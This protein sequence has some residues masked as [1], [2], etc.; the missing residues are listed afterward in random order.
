MG[1]VSALRR[2]PAVLLMV[3]AAFSWGAGTVVTKVTL[4][5]LSPLDVLGVELLVGT[6]AIWAA[7]L[8]RGGPRGL[9]GWRGFAVLGTL[10]P[11][12]SFALFDFGLDRTGAADGAILLASESLFAALLAWAV[13][14][15]RFGRRATVAIGVGF[16]GS[17]IVGLGETGHGASL[18]GDALV[19]AASAAAA[20]YGVAARRIATDGDTDALTVTGVQLLAAT[21]LVAP[22]VIGGAVAGHSHLGH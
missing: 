4:Q 7:L 12:L 20:A 11:A 19:L 15:E 14:G 22:V 2:Q 17:V 21:V 3:A 1:R 10:E 6:V 18:L 8:L 5:Q 16:A 9:A 13:L